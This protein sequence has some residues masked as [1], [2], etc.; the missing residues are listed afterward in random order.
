M[1]TPAVQPAAARP[2]TP[3][4]APTIARAVAW[5]A[6]LAALFVGPIGAAVSAQPTLRALWA[7]L[8]P[9][10]AA[11]ALLAL[12]A[13]LLDALAACADA[14]MLR[15]APQRETLLLSVLLPRP[16]SGAGDQD[17]PALLRALHGAI[18][19][20][21]GA[22][23]VALIYRCESGQP[24]TLGV[25]IAGRGRALERAAIAVR[26]AIGGA[27]PAAVV[28]RAAPP[29]SAPLLRR[30]MQLALPSHYPLAGGELDSLA[31][32][33]L[34]AA[35]RPRGAA[36]ATMVWVGLMPLRRPEDASLRTG[37]RGRALALRMRLEQR[38]DYAL[39][40]D[41]AAIG[42]KLDALP[43]AAT[44]GIDVWADGAGAATHGDAALADARQT[45]DGIVR[46]L[47]SA[48]QRIGS[49]SQ[50]LVAGAET[51]RRDARH[52]FTFPR[53]PE[54]PPRLLLPLG[55]RRAP[56]VLTDAELATFW[57]LPD[58]AAAQL[59]GWLGARR[60]PAPPH[61]FADG[62]D[63]IVIGHASDSDGVE[64]PVGP[65]LHDL[66]QI[67]HITAGMGAGKSR[68][69]ANLCQQFLPHGM[70]LIDGKGDDR[71]GSLVAT[72]RRLIPLADEGRLALLD[73]LDSDW[74]VSLNPLAGVTRAT[75]DLALG[76]VLALFGRLDPETWAK[77]AGMQ[78]Y[79]QMATLLVL[80]GE[81]SPTL[82]HVRQALTEDDYRETL[83]PL[84]TNLEVV[85]FWR[86]TFPRL[87]DS[88]KQ[89]RDALLRRFDILLTAE[90]TRHMLTQAG[91]VFDLTAAI[92]RR[93]IVLAPLPDMTLG[94]LAG[95][96]GALVF[97]AFVRGA[98]AR[99]GSDATRASY[100]LVIDELQVL[101]AGASRE[102]ETAI[103]RLRS[104]GIPAV[105]AHQALSQ[106][107][108][109][110]GLMQ[111]NAA[112]RVILQT[113]E[114]DASVY[115]K[116]YAASGLTAADIAGQEPLAHQYAVLR[117]GGA[118]AGPLSIRPL[119][120]P[121][122][123]EAAPCDGGEEIRIHVD[124]ETGR[125]GGAE[126]GKCR[127]WQR[128]LP[129]SGDALDALVAELAYGDAQDGEVLALL[130]ALDDRR[131]ARVCARWEA[132]RAAQ[133][134]YLLA[135]PAACPD[136]M[137]RQRWLSRLLIARPRLLA[138]AEYARAR[139][140]T[141]PQGG[142]RERGTAEESARPTGAGRRDRAR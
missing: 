7:L 72:V 132:V 34:L 22:P 60:L 66:R 49:R 96:L 118:A 85:S 98:F 107:G 83:L 46:A 64:R 65:T 134:A 40:P 32:G 35:A 90:T 84:A 6:L 122:P 11:P 42:A 119:G 5:L 36:T 62:G 111:I 58:A 8:A 68:L 74:P 73:S 39:A 16:A 131:W 31:L 25:G 92:D 81:P 24:A 133:R 55:L 126:P 142:R 105:Y 12:L 112:N 140:A 47:Q 14:A 110:A 88:Q 113:G 54:P 127:D 26:T 20:G 130:A 1:I 103:T 114:P 51:R 71:D 129:A 94:G 102:M 44:I 86:E 89:S 109:L 9:Q 69:L 59:V 29:A 128:V 125:P 15:A 123:I 100:P 53:C 101:A 63:R 67:L 93:L 52:S 139:T 76:Q 141:A 28:E 121:E 3:D 50:G 80:S 108:E 41:L 18:P 10:L 70:M 56:D 115:A 17:P 117:C 13:L 116:M 33:Q 91:G 124:R 82:A 104:L 19:A 137:E 4:R 120:W 48:R 135:H 87:G 138:A 79:L 27:C 95:A 43:F 30:T 57:R 75:T 136:R 78:Q 77:A 21:R 38:H 45:M 61:A 37:W 97:E 23:T 2:P 106:L 99:S